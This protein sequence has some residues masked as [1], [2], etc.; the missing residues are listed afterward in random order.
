MVKTTVGVDIAGK[1]C[2]FEEICYLYGKLRAS[3]CSILYLVQ[4]RRE[5]VKIVE[6]IGMFCRADPGPCGIP[7][8]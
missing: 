2:G 5:S 1:A 6:G 4:F 7:V 8:R 3:R